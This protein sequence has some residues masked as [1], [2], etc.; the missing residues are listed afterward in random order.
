MAADVDAQ[1]RGTRVGVVGGYGS[2]DQ[3]WTPAMTTEPVGGVVI[4]AFV[5]ASTP[6]DWLS[7]TLEGTYTQRGGDVVVYLPGGPD[8]GSRSAIRADYLTISVQPRGTVAFGP[9]DLHLTTGPV[10]DQLIRSRTSAELRPELGDGRGTVFAWSAGI[11]AGASITERTH[12]ELEV[13]L[14]RGLGDA[15]DGDF[16][17]VR[18]RSI[19][20]VGRLGLPW[21]SR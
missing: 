21:P 15:Y 18:N 5:N 20:F 9:V 19:E 11:G 13:R 10:L 14:V 17:T 7:I 8:E 2:T 4:G 1:S 6:S 12:A 16:V 3:V